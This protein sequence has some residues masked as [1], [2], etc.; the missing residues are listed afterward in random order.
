LAELFIGEFNLLAETNYHVKR[1]YL[2]PYNLYFFVGAIVLGIVSGLYP[3]LA[4][5]SFKTVEV[6]KGKIS[7]SRGGIIARKALMVFSVCNFFNY[8]CWF[9]CDLS[10][11]KSC[12][13]LQ[14]L[15]LIRKM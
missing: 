2:Y 14:I 1:F 10:S 13:T 3:A 11:D 5:T 7:K 8:D 15:G 6:I 4:L 9:H 12:K